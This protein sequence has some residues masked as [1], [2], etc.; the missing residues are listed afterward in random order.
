MLLYFFQEFSGNHS[1]QR[2]PV[3]KYD[4]FFTVHA[5]VQPIIKK[6]NLDPSVLSSF[7][8]ISKLPFLS[9]VLEK[10]VLEQL[11][12]HLDLNDI[13]EKFQSGFKS[14]HSTETALLKIFNDLLL[15]VDSGSSA[16]LVL[17]DLT[18]AFDTVDHQILLSRLELCVGIT[19][20]VL[21]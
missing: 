12:L 7:R 13:A 19:G 18:A 2:F 15:T 9:K 6:H 10:V 4:F 3:K 8:P 16:A 1:C 11:Q 17:L 5:I 14:R 20:N 21:K